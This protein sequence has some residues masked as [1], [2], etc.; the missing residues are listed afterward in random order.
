MTTIKEVV[1]VLAN[2]APPALQESYDNSGLLIGDDTK[3][4]RGVLIC[5]D[6]TEEIIEEAAR[7]KCNLIISHH[8]LL[9]SPLKRITGKNYIERSVIK[10]IQKQI[11]VYAIHTNLDNV[12]LGVNKIIADKLGLINTKILQPM[13]NLLKKLVTFCPLKHSEKVR[14]ALFNA[15]GGRIG[16]YDEC[17][18][19]VSGTGT[20]RGSEKTNPFVGKRGVQHREQE[21]RIEMIFESFRQKKIV[22][23]LLASHPY[24]EVAY[25]IYTLENVHQ[26]IGAGLIGELK[27]PVREVSF[28]RMVKKNMQTGCLR[29]TKL[30]GNNVQRVAVCGGSGSFLLKDA[31]K[32]G[33]GVFVTADF[34]YHQ[35]FDA[36]GTIVIADIGHFESEQFTTEIIKDYLSDNFSTFA[37]RLAETVTNPI[38]Y[39]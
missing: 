17:S 19:M 12:P 15:G 38:Q 33:V 39:L 31:I 4:I 9:F 16:N 27:N 3:K 18:F 30:L 24:E 6:V 23:A 5:I 32:S 28:L 11:S 7:K 26:N 2:L 14:R 34:K 20:F 21:E 35:F 29:H 10:A 37:I 25:D 8:P 1:S 36:E 22:N 13:T